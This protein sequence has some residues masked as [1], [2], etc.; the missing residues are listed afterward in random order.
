MRQNNAKDLRVFTFQVFCKINEGVVRTHIRQ[1]SLSKSRGRGC[2]SWLVRI[3]VSIIGLAL[4][5]F[6]YERVAEG[7]D[8]KAYPP[9]G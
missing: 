4:I 2:L 3:V 9:P 8:A 6:V 7:A 5:G 1:V